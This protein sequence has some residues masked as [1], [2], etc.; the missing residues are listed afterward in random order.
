MERKGI[1]TTGRDKHFNEFCCKWEHRNKI[2]DKPKQSKLFLRFFY[3]NEMIIRHG[4]VEDNRR[5]G[6]NC[7]S[8]VCE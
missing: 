1:D 6:E 2:L 3:G 8:D 5:V 7:C 4:K